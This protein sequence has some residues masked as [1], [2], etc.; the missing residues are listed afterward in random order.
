[1]LS[2]L[3]LALRSLVKSPGFTAVA[4]ITL[5]LGVGANTAVFSVV[6]A[7]LLRLLPL[8]AAHELAFLSESSEQVPNMSVA[9]PNLVD[10]RAR[11]R[12]F[13]SLG[14]FRNQGFNYLGP[15]EAEPMNGAHVSHDL[16]TTLGVPPRLGR[17]FTAAED[18]PG[19]ERTVLISERLWKRYFRESPD[20][21]GQ[22]INLS[23]FI[24]TVVGVMPTSFEFPSPSTELWAPVAL[25]LGEA[26][27]A[28]R[29]SHPGLYVIGRMKPGVTLDAARADL[30]GVARQLAEEFPATNRGN[31]A[32]VQLLT[33]RTFGRIRPA[34]LAL[35]A[36]AAFVLLIACANVANLLLARAA[37]RS[38]EL[39]VRAA[40]GAGRGRLVR[41]LLA[42]SALLGLLGAGAGLLVALWSIEAI[43]ATLPSQLPNLAQIGLS[44]PVFV[45]A[46]CAGVG[47]SVLFGLVPAFSATRLNLSA[48]LSQS[49]RAGGSVGAARWRG[50]LIAGEFALTVALL[51]CA[52]L[53]LRTLGNLYRADPGFRTEQRLSFNWA[54]S[55]QKYADPKVRVQTLTQTLERL[56][57]LPGVQRVGLIAPL[58][59]SGGG[60]QT[61]FRPETLPDPGPGKFP[62][63]E[64][65]PV[66][67][68]Y[69]STMGI[70]LVKGRVF[71]AHD[72]ADSQGVCII[73]TTLAEK[74]YP[75]QDPIGQRLTLGTLPT[76]PKLEIV[77][78]V[79]H[80][81][82]Y[83]IGQPT[84]YQT[85]RPYAQQPPFA[86]A[87]VLHTAGDP[88]ALTAEVRRT[89]R[90]VDPTLPIFQVRTMAETFA[91]TI[92]TQRLALNLLGLFAA[93]ALVLAAVGLYGVLSYAVGQRTREFGVRLAIGADARSVVRLVV[94]QGLKLAVIGLACG[95]ALAAG[96]AWL[97]RTQ[98]HDV[99]P[100]DPLSYVVVTALLLGVGVIACLLPAL[101]A[102]RVNPVEA[103]RAE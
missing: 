33:E 87:F 59:L 53:M 43:R 50:A 73:D 14:G 1:M 100:F 6:N 17:F 19:A 28:N 89:I 54:L 9:Y 42:E 57:A 31:S 55:G 58:P 93:L 64:I 81:Q 37:A 76:N 63:T 5:A 23:G 102:T 32:A 75:G 40:L 99:S 65:G 68:E 94:A 79:A 4:I 98:F 22:K 60:N 10:W 13:S 83:G 12:S 15:T 103:L 41:Q 34:L 20:A 82:N 101:R 51:V 24:Y 16:F 96:A 47:T 18:K 44:A 67:P 8:P 91:S 56:A 95:L 49:A 62:S 78:V 86:C 66:N 36:A 80:I 70:P 52:G 74:F 21:L 7:L 39:V 72:T 69:F 26:M 84:R 2:D 90:D 30:V 38:R 97:M 35:F 25:M 48:A 45:F 92:T 77:G 46:L 88:A 11:Q 27:V 61:T 85:Y 71:N 29:G 3:R